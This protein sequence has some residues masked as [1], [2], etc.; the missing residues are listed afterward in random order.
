MYKIGVGR[1]AI[2]IEI[3]GKEFA[4]KFVS[5][6]ARKRANDLFSMVDKITKLSQLDTEEKDKAMDALSEV[7]LKEVLD[8]RGD[9]IENLVTSNGYEYDADWWEK[10]TAYEDQ[11]Q[12]IYLCILKDVSKKKQQVETQ[13]K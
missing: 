6:F 8:S 11:N 12:F 7:E 5:V 3:G 13:K 9:C 4:I 2:D 1:E 10:N